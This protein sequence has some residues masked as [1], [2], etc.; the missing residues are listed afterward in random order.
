MGPGPARRTGI[1]RPDSMREK[2]EYET[3]T[4]KHCPPCW[5]RVTRRRG[6]PFGPRWDL[7]QVSTMTNCGKLAV[8]G[9]VY[10]IFDRRKPSLWRATR[11]GSHQPSRPIRN[12]VGRRKVCGRSTRLTVRRLRQERLTG[13]GPTRTSLGCR[14]PEKRPSTRSLVWRTGQQRT[15]GALP[16]P[17]RRRPRAQI[18]CTPAEESQLVPGRGSGFLFQR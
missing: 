15:D 7:M 8:A 16:A 14:R 9:K 12:G 5:A 4:I 1:A 10:T 13:S 2:Y 18:D 17:V 3:I 6:S 11:T